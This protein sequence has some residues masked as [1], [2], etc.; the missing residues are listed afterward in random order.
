MTR[1]GICLA[2]VIAVVLGYILPANI[3]ARGTAIFFG[4]CA[5]SFLPMYTCGLFWRR[6][7]RLGAISGL[8]VGVLAWLL[9]TVFMHKAEAVPL[10]IAKALLGR[11]M[12]ITQ[13]PWPVVDPIV[14]ALPLAFLVTIAVSLVTE[15][16]N[17]D[18][19]DKCF[20]GVK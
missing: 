19:V 9:W 20:K 1:V 8:V 10:G 2:V 4:L 7:T 13:M 11:D 14:I 18:Y 16:M 6:T 17:K 3:I 15:Q 5:A 12:L